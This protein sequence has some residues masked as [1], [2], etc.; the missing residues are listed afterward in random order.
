MATDGNIK[1]DIPKDKRIKAEQ[2]KL[3]KLFKIKTT[4]ELSGKE[5][6]ENTIKDTPVERLIQRAAFMKVLLEDIEKDINEHGY[7]EMFTQSKDAPAYERKRP[8]VELY[9]TTVKNFSSV[10][11]TLQDLLPKDGIESR[12]KE[13]EDFKKFVAQRK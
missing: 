4:D 2:N 13:L 11:K 5:K 3:S 6:L 8:C 7:T 10:C 9:N 1:A 12:N